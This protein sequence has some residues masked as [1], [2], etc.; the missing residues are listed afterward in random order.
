[1]KYCG[2]IGFF[3]GNEEVSPGV[4]KPKIV[5][6]HPYYGDVLENKRRFQAVSDKQN[7]DLVLSSRISVLSDLYMQKHWPSVRYVIWNGVYWKV[8]DVDVGIPRII[9][10]LGG[11]Y[12]GPFPGGTS[13]KAM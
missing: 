7:D 4:F 12:N 10:T 2:T 11:V 9:L 8:V 1:M 3:E 5:E 13:C 6:K